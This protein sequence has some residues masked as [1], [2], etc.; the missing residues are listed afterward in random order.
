MCPAPQD[1][2][3][4]MAIHKISIPRWAV[5]LRS[6][7]TAVEATMAILTAVVVRISERGTTENN[8]Q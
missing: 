7:F 1:D 2:K 6:I 5:R 8:K 4:L 3:S